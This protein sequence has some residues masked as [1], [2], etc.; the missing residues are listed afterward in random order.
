MSDT[1][2]LV[3]CGKMGGALLEGWLKAGVAGRV[4][5][6]EPYQ[7]SVPDHPAILRVDSAEDIP[8]D[9]DP[10]CIVFAVKP[11]AMADILPAYR[12][13][14]GGRAVFLSIAAGKTIGFFTGALG[15]GSA[16]VRAMPNTPAAIGKGISVLVSSPAVDPGQ[17]A[18][19]G[20]LMAAAGAV[21]WVEDEGLID[22][23]TALSG[24]GPAYVFLLI[25]TLA[26]AGRASGLPGDLAERLARQTVIGAGALA[27]ASS[28][29]AG[30]LRRNV[31][32]PNG[33]TQAALEVLMAEDGVQPLFDSAIAAAT[34]RSRELA[35]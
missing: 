17:R 20:R 32:S 7:D 24:G 2:L 27:E 12:R 4:C 19:C 13:F 26:A 31:T 8:A 9:L 15:D 29:P 18:L 23:V 28:E 30:T 16:I 35:S 21:E 14:A 1:V 34:R 10:A 33:T 5:V 22:A 25:E 6:V 11:Q 3:G